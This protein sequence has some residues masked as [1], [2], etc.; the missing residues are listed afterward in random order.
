[1]FTALLEE[2]SMKLEWGENGLI[3]REDLDS[4]IFAHNIVSLSDSAKAL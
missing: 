2:T 3:T 1:M 4:L